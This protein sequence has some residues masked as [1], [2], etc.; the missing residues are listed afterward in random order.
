MQR[1][2][3]VQVGREVRERIDTLERRAMGERERAF[4]RDQLSRERA[5]NEATR[6]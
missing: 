1:W 3:Q 5:A 4:D 6:D 2:H